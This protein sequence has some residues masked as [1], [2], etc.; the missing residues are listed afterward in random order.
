MS[1]S[2]NSAYTLGAKD[3]DG[4]STT[5]AT[6]VEINLQPTVANSSGP[7]GPGRRPRS[8]SPRADPA[9]KVPAAH[10]VRPVSALPAPPSSI[11]GPSLR[12]SMGLTAADTEGAKGCGAGDGKTC[13]ARSKPT[14]VARAE[15]DAEAAVSASTDGSGA[16]PD[17]G[18]GDRKSVV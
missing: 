10:N 5:S 15:G 13:S 7:Y 9:L 6:S 3:A 14:P 2:G 17:A 12:N 11:V 8:S 16:K 1:S 18:G 4:M